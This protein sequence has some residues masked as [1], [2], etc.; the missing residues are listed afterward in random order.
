MA[1][2]VLQ[3]FPDPAPLRD[4]LGKTGAVLEPLGRVFGSFSADH[5]DSPLGPVVSA[6][7]ALEVQA[8]VDVSGLAIRLPKTLETLNGALPASALEYVDSIHEAYTK[9]QDFLSK[10]PLLDD[11]PPGK[12]PQDVALATLGEAVKL[13]EARVQ[14]LAR[15]LIPADTLRTITTALNDL[16]QLVTDFNGHSDQLLPFLARNLVGVV[17]DLLSAPL[18]YVQTS[19]APVA[20]LEPSALTT[21]LDGPRTALVTARDR[22]ATAIST[23]NPDD[24]QGYA[25]IVQALST[26]EQAAAGLF[27]VMNPLYTQ[28]QGG[29][30]ANPWEGLAPRYQQ[31]L[32]AI[33]FVPAAT[34]DDV[35]RSGVELITS[36][37]EG[38]KR[39]NGVGD[40]QEHIDA[41]GHSVR[42][43]A[44]QSA[45]GQ[46]RGAMVD[47]ITQIRDAIQAVPTEQIQAGVEQMLGRV[48]Q[49]LDA[50]GVEQI[51]TRIEKGFQE[52]EAFSAKSVKGVAV[53][54]NDVLN[55]ALAQA[56]SGVEQLLGQLSGALKT[57]SDLITEAE[58][59]VKEQLDKI[60]AFLAKLEQVSFK[61]VGDAVVSEINEL[62]DR[63]RAIDPNALSDV[64]KLAIKAALAMLEALDL[65]NQAIKALKEGFATAENQVKGLLDELA[66]ALQRLKSNL[67]D[68]NPDT[69]L[70]PLAG[71]LAQV[72]GLVDKLQGRAL[73]SPLRDRAAALDKALASLSPGALLSPLQ[74]P[75][76]RLMVQVNRLD[77]AQWLTPLKDLYA[78]IDRLIAWVDVTPL[79]EEL[80]KREDALLASARSALLSALDALSLP[81]PLASFFAGVRPVV[82]GLTAALLTDPATELPKLSANIRDR[83]K[84]TDAFKALDPLF[85][86]LVAML[87]SA[88]RTAV[89]TAF[90]TLRTG[91]SVALETIDPWTLRSRLLEALD[92][93]A[94]LSP[95]RMLEPLAQLASMKRAFQATASLAVEDR[96]GEIVTVNARF[97]AV[98]ALVSPESA[99]GA[100]HDLLQLHDAVFNALQRGVLSVDLTPAADA[101]ARIRE[102]LDARLPGFIRR[103]E[104]LVWE[105]IQT[106]LASL[107]PSTRAAP[108]AQAADAF[109]ADL[110][111]V[112]TALASTINGFFSALR[113]VVRLID[114]RSLEDEVKTVYDAIHAKVRILDPDALAA[115]LR[116]HVLDPLRAP[117]E[118]IDPSKLATRLDAAYTRARTAV[119]DSVTSVL[120][121]A[122][123]TLEQHLSAVR[124]ELKRLLAQVNGAATQALGGV[125]DILD[126]VEKLILVE[127]IERLKRVAD[128]LNVS[129]GEELDRVRGAFDAMLQA[130]PL[131]GAPQAAGALSG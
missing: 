47:F 72:S 17:P 62:R 63:L 107:R 68:F 48:K 87:Q 102:A 106:G 88:P 40:L 73:V 84:V 43:A 8:N 7:G 94:R 49:E 86:K 11:L 120:D 22:L 61:P 74:E 89:I 58:K 126:R 38:L 124:A 99:A 79:L 121:N 26:L 108:L 123:Q 116:T 119:A 53:Q 67:G 31:L 10:L 131:G 15:S 44:L 9:A 45:L 93:L 90:N 60:Q 115:S 70:K 52:L 64:E 110:Q 104:A 28:L 100:L 109:L 50:L 125:K 71:A 41:L 23:L 129:F 92:R 98:I 36:M 5:S 83:F 81:E 54:L 6:M 77:P 39:A 34:L 2:G 21:A 85:D 18:E 95:R 130:I 114:P 101:Y 55:G 42:E 118:A 4:T 30:E 82:E 69:L 3:R 20:L 13:F 97:D 78:Q 113:D 25:A 57:I 29:L 103:N 117:L 24:P 122:E 75:Y 33:Q 35:V 105:D 76:Q 128:K 127:L 46:V 1:D 12:T 56:R 19:L 51:A 27:G 96:A 91:L 32:E 37:R 112:A 16:N 111:P 66:A 14:E 80:G 59:A 65:E